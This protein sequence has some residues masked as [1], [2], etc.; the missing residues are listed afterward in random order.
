MN[1]LGFFL[2]AGMILCAAAGCSSG[3][4]QESSQP[5][6]QSYSPNPDAGN[7]NAGPLEYKDSY[8]TCELQDSYDEGEITCYVDS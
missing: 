8:A 4:S 1:R 6:T 7:N 5:F 3:G 2:I